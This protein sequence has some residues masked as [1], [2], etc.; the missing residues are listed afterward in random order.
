MLPVRSLDPPGVTTIIRPP[1]VGTHS[2]DKL[3]I[4][5]RTYYM[6]S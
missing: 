5:D 6:S 3:D 4:I 1:R 2:N